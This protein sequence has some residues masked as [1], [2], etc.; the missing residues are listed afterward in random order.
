[1]FEALD[2]IPHTCAGDGEGEGREGRREGSG[3]LALLYAVS[4]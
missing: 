4:I 2:L 3:L 1:M